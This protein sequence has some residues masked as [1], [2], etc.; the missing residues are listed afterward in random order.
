MDDLHKE[1]L[2]VWRKEMSLLIKQNE[3]SIQSNIDEMTILHKIN[4]L[5]AEEIILYQKSIDQSFKKTES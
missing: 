1:C 2:D 4:L 5:R 3:M